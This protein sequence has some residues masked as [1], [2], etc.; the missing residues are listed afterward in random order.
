MAP[1]YYTWQMAGCS[2]ALP[3]QWGTLWSGGNSTTWSS[4]THDYDTAPAGGD[5]IL[6]A[7]EGVNAGAFYD[8]FYFNVGTWTGF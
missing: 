3:D 4:P 8:Q 7:C 2:G 5:A 1:C 6:L